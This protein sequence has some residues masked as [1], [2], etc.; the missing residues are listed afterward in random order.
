MDTKQ[1]ETATPANDHVTRSEHDCIM[2]AAEHIGQAVAFLR[3]AATE[4]ALINAAELQPW[5][6]RVEKIA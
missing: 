2:W 3:M 5:V 1:T 6:E 4:D